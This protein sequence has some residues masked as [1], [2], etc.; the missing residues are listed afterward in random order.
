MH[1]VG[2]LL[3]LLRLIQVLLR[4]GWMLPQMGL[5]LSII[6]MSLRRVW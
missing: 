2:V 6:R 4:T 5:L 3:L 1:L